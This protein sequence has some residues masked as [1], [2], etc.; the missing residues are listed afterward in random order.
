MGSIRRWRG[1]RGRTVTVT[2]KPAD[3]STLERALGEG[4]LLLVRVGIA[5]AAAFLAGAVV[6]RVLLGRYGFKAGGLE[7]DDV[8]SAAEASV[9]ALEAMK[10][11]VDEHQSTLA[12]T[13]RTAA[14]AMVLAAEA[15][16]RL[17]TGTTDGVARSTTPGVQ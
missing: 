12:S 10:A 14:E 11:I 6:L 8:T 5:A 16:R 1:R 3:D 4:G 13:M 2:S 17:E 7:M 9:E 15:T